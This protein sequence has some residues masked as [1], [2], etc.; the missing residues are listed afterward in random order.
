MGH[1]LAAIHP[2]RVIPAEGLGQPFVHAHVEVEHDEDGGLQAVRQVEGQGAE[3][4]ALARVHRQQH[5]V[6]GVT[7]AGIGG[8]D[9]V[10]LLGAGRHA[11]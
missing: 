6:L 8:P 3:G 4:E 9:Q 11:R 5:G 2:A 10:R 1:D 7:M